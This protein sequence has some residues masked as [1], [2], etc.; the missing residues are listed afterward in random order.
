MFWDKI[1]RAG[2]SKRVSIGN[3]KSKYPTTDIEDKLPGKEA[4]IKLYWNT[5]PHVGYL[6]DTQFGEVAIKVPD[7]GEKFVLPQ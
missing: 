3:L 7:I 1:I 4:F 5:V 6:F 2:N